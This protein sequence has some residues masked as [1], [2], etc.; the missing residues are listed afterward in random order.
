MN[1]IDYDLGAVFR[2]GFR[3]FVFNFIYRLLMS[4]YLKRG[5]RKGREGEREGGRDNEGLC[6]LLFFAHLFWL[7]IRELCCTADERDLK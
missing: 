4:N 2:G 7:M 3:E 1:E 6:M 5:G